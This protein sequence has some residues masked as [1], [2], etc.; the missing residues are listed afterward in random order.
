VTKVAGGT[1][2]PP[3]PPPPS[4]D[5]VKVTEAVYATS[6]KRLSIRASSTDATATLTAY[7]TSTNTLIGTLENR[8]DGSYRGTFKWPTNPQNV[9]VRSSSG[10][11]DSRA[12][13]TTK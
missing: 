6:S 10:G 1:S 13:T 12:V 7:V 11:A 8:G 9:T 3:P 5:V 4:S 2:S